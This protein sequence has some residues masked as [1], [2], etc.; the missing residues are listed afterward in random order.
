MKEIILGLKQKKNLLLHSCCAPCSSS[1]IEKLSSYFNITVFFYNP[2]IL[3]KNEYEKRKKEQINFININNEKFNNNINFIEGDYDP[4]IFFSCITGKEKL[5]EG[6]VRCKE[7]YKMRIEKTAEYAKKNNFDFFGTT[8]SVSPH[9]N[10]NWINEIMIEISN[11]LGIK[12]LLAGFKKENGYLRSLEL[13]KSY[14][15]YRQ[16]YCGCNLDKNNH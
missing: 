11:K 3:P 14:N 13:S 1:V 5:G 8:L 12:P 7:C 16:N 4:N 6:S 9:K 10:S 15:L 2:N